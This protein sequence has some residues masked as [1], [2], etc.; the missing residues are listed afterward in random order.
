MEHIDWMPNKWRTGARG[1]TGIQKLVYFVC[2]NETYAAGEAIPCDVD[3]ITAQINGGTPETADGEA[4]I[5]KKRVKTAI[6]SL[7]N[8]GKIRRTP[9]VFHDFLMPNHC[10]SELEACKTRMENARRNGKSGGRPKKNQPL[11]ETPGFSEKNP[12]VSDEKT[13]SVRTKQNKT[14]QNPL[15][16]HEAVS[17][18]EGEAES[19]PSE[20]GAITDIG[21]LLKT[22]E[23]DQPTRRACPRDL[24]TNPRANGTNPRAYTPPP[25]PPAA[26]PDGPPELMPLWDRMR[27][28][29]GENA[30]RTWFAPLKVQEVNGS[31]SLLAP[32]RFHRDH[33]LQNFVDRMSTVAGLPIVI[34]FAR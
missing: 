4:P 20:A 6:N 31:L 33:C 17:D 28:E 32:S 23:T 27:S 34:G 11:S 26:P 21:S 13:P 14:K 22:M 3:W 25:I 30:F 1:L 7:V 19:T 2:I 5:S 24:G 18:Q 16:P 15:T 8:L 9:G 12:P 29:F 10:E